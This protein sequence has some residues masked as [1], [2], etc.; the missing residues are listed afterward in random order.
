ML[1]LSLSLSKSTVFGCH[2]VIIYQ[3]PSVSKIVSLL[4]AGNLQLSTMGYP[5]IISSDHSHGVHVHVHMLTPL[6][7][8]IGIHT[9]DE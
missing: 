2:T 4:I 8:Y 7:M 3:E 9:V 1:K 5:H 6:L